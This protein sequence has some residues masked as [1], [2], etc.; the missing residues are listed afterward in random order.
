MNQ[1][2]IIS[3]FPSL[4]R[5][6]K[7]KKLVYLDGPAGTQVPTAVIDAISNYYK[8]SNANSHGFFVTTHET[9]T[10]LDNTRQKIA[11]FLGAA[12]PE[13]IS[14]GANM[15]TLNYSLARA[16]GRALQPGDEILI[17]QL[18]HEANRAPWLSLRESGIVVREV[19]LLADGTLDYED[20]QSKINERTRLVAMGYASNIFGTVNEVAKIRK[21]TYEVG[22]WLLLDAVHYAP[23]FPIDVQAVGCD[24][25]LCSAYKF[26]GPHIGILY[27][28]DGLLDRL[29][30][31]R[32]RTAPQAAP[33][34][35][36]TGTQNHAAL[37]GTGA[38]VDFIAVLG[39]GSSYRDKIL[40]GMKQIRETETKHFKILWEGL[41]KISKI[42][43][44]GL[45]ADH[46]SRT[47]TV[48]FTFEGL[49]AKELC[50]RLG[51]EGICAWDGHFYAIRSTE[52]LGLL[53]RGGVT[54]MGISLYN[55]ESDIERTLKVLRKM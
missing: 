22:A 53:E 31:D 43:T 16:I 23:H 27:C 49:T 40:S 45:P 5:T 12:G 17:T 6:Y 9:D 25:L 1:E 15:T 34:S 18:D 20:I 39:R 21:W 50:Q 36:E 54:R 3:Q 35:I 52:V 51:E 14:W 10:M 48:S 32:L 4:Q 38:A 29:P 26:Y 13:T 44:F 2:K 30:T 28:K 7:R 55:T 37:A 47:P 33:Y 19:R 24:F 8:N 11:D 41:Q 42:T 46:P